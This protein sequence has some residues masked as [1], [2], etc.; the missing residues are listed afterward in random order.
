MGSFGKLR[1][2]TAAQERRGIERADWQPVR[3]LIGV[4]QPSYEASISVQSASATVAE[5][6]EIVCRLQ[7]TMQVPS[8]P[9]PIDY[10]EP[11]A[12]ARDA[13]LAFLH[14]DKSTT[15][16]MEPDGRLYEHEQVYVTRTRNAATMCSEAATLVFVLQ[17]GLDKRFIKEM[18]DTNNWLINDAGLAATL[19]SPG[20]GSM[21]KKVAT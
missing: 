7:R 16:V 10:T 19:V 13:I 6:F 18:D 12:V 2:L 14:A 9:C 8:Y 21:H 4:L 20:G 1:N 15:D 11:L 3:H 5:A 17:D